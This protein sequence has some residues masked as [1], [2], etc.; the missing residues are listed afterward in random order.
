MR[1][2]ISLIMGTVLAVSSLSLPT[3][4]QKTAKVKNPLSPP[5][6]PIRVGKSPAG[7]ASPSPVGAQALATVTEILN[8]CMQVDSANA[9]FYRKF[10]SVVISGSSPSDIRTDE[11]SSGYQAEAKLIDQ[12]LAATPAGT[13]VTSCRTIVP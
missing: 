12:Q 3:Q 5:S 2:R 8:K 6:N 9:G 1:L 10:Q 13:M 7:L 4:A 11:G